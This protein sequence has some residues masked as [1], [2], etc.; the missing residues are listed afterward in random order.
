MTSEK[1]QTGAFS[2]QERIYCSS[3]TF[4]LLLG[5]PSLFSKR[6]VCAAVTDSEGGH[7]VFQEAWTSTERNGSTSPLGVAAGW[8]HRSDLSAS[9]PSHVPSENP[10]GG[11][12]K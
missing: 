6:R 11:I 7:T 4:L 8:W 10:E 1:V 12:R 5:S 9:S 3:S 2:Q